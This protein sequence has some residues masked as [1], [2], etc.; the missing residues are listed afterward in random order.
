[1]LFYLKLVAK[2]DQPDKKQ[3]NGKLYG[4][5][6]FDRFPGPLHIGAPV[7]IIKNHYAIGVQAG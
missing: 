4:R 1:M 6:L 5:I 2:K 3:V 7:N